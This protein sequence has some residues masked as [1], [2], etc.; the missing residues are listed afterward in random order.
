MCFALRLLLWTVLITLVI[1][2]ALIFRLFRLRRVPPPPQPPARANTPATPL[3]SAWRC[4][5]CLIRRF[6]GQNGLLVPGALPGV[7]RYLPTEER[8]ERATQVDTG[9]QTDS[10]DQNQPLDLSTSRP[11]DR[12]LSRSPPTLRRGPGPPWLRSRDTWRTLGRVGDWD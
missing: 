8:E 9:T 2:F 1:A 4:A 6:R 3:P 7:F 10:P 5:R 12:D 11:L